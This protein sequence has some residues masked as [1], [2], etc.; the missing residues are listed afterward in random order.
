[1]DR[2]EEGARSRPLRVFVCWSYVPV[3][4]GLHQGPPSVCWRT[5]HCIQWCTHPFLSAPGTGPEPLIPDEPC[6]LR[7]FDTCTESH[8]VRPWHFPTAVTE[9]G[10]TWRKSPYTFGRIQFQHDEPTLAQMALLNLRLGRSC[11][12]PITFFLRVVSLPIIMAPPAPT[13]TQKKSGTWMGPGGIRG[14]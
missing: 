13:T 1:M 11:S 8:Q 7:F 10:T 12:G 3:C 14:V 6:W 9:L 2:V 4:M 5:A